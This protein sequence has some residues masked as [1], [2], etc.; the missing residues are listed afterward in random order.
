MRLPD[1]RRAGAAAGWF[2]FFLFATYLVAVPPTADDVWWRLH[3]GARILE[4]GRVQDVNGWAYRDP[5]AAW[6]DHAAGHD[7]I[8]AATHR[9]A[10]LPGAVFLYALPLLWL[11]WGFGR[12]RKRVDWIWAL[13]WPPL[14]AIHHALR[15]YV[16]SDA[17]FFLAVLL[18]TRW[19]ERDAPRWRE[20][21]P[22]WGLFLLWGQLHGAVWP[23][24]AFT[25]AFAARWRDRKSVV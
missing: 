3:A 22:L 8:L 24:L 6:V 19:H 16:W 4:T 2:P 9:G 11:A 14:L 12:P 23:G 13:T 7:V 20:A 5:N 10:G 17:L 21:A 1:R 18:A 15:P 25:L